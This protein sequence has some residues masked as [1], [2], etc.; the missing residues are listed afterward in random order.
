MTTLHYYTKSIELKDLFKRIFLKN[1]N[2]LTLI[3][4][5]NNV[6]SISIL[7]F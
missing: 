3:K 6:A 2:L 5:E 7:K 4:K 1:K